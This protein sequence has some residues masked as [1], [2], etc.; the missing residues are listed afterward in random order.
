M[1]DYFYEHQHDL[2]PEQVFRTD[3]GNVVKLGRP[4]PGDGSKWYVADFNVHTGKWCYV[5]STLEPGELAERLPDD[6]PRRA[7]I[8]KAKGD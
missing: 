8:A 3:Y 7:A 6:W 5:G 1:A 2:D 4:V